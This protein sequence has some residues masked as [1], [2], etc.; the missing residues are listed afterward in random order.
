M[1]R[2]LPPKRHTN[3]DRQ[4]RSPTPP[5]AVQSGVDLFELGGLR[6]EDLEESYPAIEEVEGLRKTRRG[7]EVCLVHCLFETLTPIPTSL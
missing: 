2:G 6:D 4:S 5:S 1:V 7:N 3:C